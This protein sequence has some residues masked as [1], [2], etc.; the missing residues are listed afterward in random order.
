MS[1]LNAS[2]GLNSTTTMA[3]GKI[4]Y[5]N[6]TGTIPAFKDLGGNVLSPNR[7]PLK[8]IVTGVN[9]LTNTIV[10]S[11]IYANKQLRK[12]KGLFPDGALLL[13]TPF[14]NKV[15]NET[16]KIVE[17]NQFKTVSIL[18]NKNID[19][20]IDENTLPKKRGVTWT[21]ALEKLDAIAYDTKGSEFLISTT[22]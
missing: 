5:V 9:D 20:E 4:L 19:G 13:E 10:G 8:I 11:S 21:D 12:I 2:F 14:D 7:N 3:K 22:T 15:K 1:K 18:N 16:L 6:G 17:N